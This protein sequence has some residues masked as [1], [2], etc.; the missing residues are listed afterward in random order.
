[1]QRAVLTPPFFARHS[2]IGYSGRRKAEQMPG[3]I[4]RRGKSSFELKYEAGVDPHTGRRITKY[5]NFKG[6]RREAQAKLTELLAAV[7]KGTHLGPNK[8]T[9]A[10]FVRSRVDQWEA[11]GK[12]SARTA[13]RYR[14]LVENQI[15]HIG[16]KQLQRLRPLDIEEWHTTL[17]SRGRADGKGGVAARTIK[18][19]H[20]VLSKALTDAAKN[21]LVINIVTKL[22]AAPKVPD[23][24]MVIAQ[25]VPTLVAKL[26]ASG[27]RL[28]VPA[29][30]S[31]F[32]GMRRGEVLALRW[33]CVDLDGKVIKVREAIEPTE[34]HG[35]RFKAPKSK[36][37]RRDIT[38]PDILVGVLR[39]Y[40]REQL[41]SRLKLGAGKLQAE[42]LLFTDIEDGPLSA[43]A[44][45]AA[46]GD[47]AA[48][49]GIPEVTFHALRHASQLIDAGVDIVTISKRLGHTKPDI[50]LRAPVP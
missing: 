31:L 30:L 49:V 32:T 7:A 20:R 6:T 10:E 35:I 47:Y 34:T 14:Y 15:S 4:R 19:A 8:I 9:V 22:E 17:R 39:D 12:I 23:E 46:R 29:M 26:K 48:K 43:G 5:L 16:T 24:E 44:F 25:D 28:Y 13:E 40:R 3:H 38:L 37:G 1:M 33:G 11:S 50:G 27:G 36:A 45:S 42:D 21:H 41:E 2:A 18:H